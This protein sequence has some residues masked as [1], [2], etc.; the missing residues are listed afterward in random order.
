[1]K[2]PSSWVVWDYQLSSYV[3]RLHT[4][5]MC[6]DPDH[7]RVVPP[8][9]P[10]LCHGPD[11]GSAHEHHGAP[12]IPVLR[13]PK[14]PFRLLA[15]H[16]T[17]ANAKLRTSI[18]PLGTRHDLSSA[19]NLCAGWSALCTH[20]STISAS[21][22]GTGFGAGGPARVEFE[23][24]VRWRGCRANCHQSAMLWPRLAASAA[25]RTG[26]LRL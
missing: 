1:M 18:C 4:R 15:E 21:P 23:P 6:L 20:A 22:D 16:A 25:C 5:A 24:W 8:S 26:L 3:V 17:F 2:K 10:Y 19:L 14:P 13:A 7:R 9:L 12:H 11:Y